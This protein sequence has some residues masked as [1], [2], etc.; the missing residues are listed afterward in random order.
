M[1]LSRL[2]FSVSSPMLFSLSLF[3]SCWYCNYILQCH[4]IRKLVAT[5]RHQQKKGVIIFE[6]QKEQVTGLPVAVAL[7]Q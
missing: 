1:I 3:C 5:A 7:I 6:L 2:N 4:N